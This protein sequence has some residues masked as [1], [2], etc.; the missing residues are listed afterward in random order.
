VLSEARRSL[1]TYV[2]GGTSFCDVRDVAR[3][4]AAALE[5]GLPGEAYI[6]G[7]QNLEMEEFLGAVA[8]AAGVRPPRPVP[9]AVAWA[10]A[11][12]AELA[13]LLGK[14]ARISR[15]LIRASGMYS[16]VTSARATAELGYAVRPFAESL[17]DTLRYFIAQGRL[18]P[19][20]PEL[21]AL[22]GAPAP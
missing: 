10:A 22:A 18:E 7:G 14:R 15:Q 21:A 9:Y 11:A 16:F 1:T 3:G 20:T 19:R 12:A 5:R 4:H 2:R 17:A 13:G 8:R 6:L